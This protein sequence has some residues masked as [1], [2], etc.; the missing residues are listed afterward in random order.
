MAA[1][2]IYNKDVNISSFLFREQAIKNI[3]VSDIVANL[4]CPD[5]EHPESRLTIIING[6]RMMSAPE[7]KRLMNPEGIKPM[8]VDK[9]FQEEIYL[10]NNAEG[11]HVI[12]F[13][14]EDFIH[15]DKDTE[16]YVLVGEKE[17]IQ[18]LPTAEQPAQAEAPTAAAPGFL[19]RV[20]SALREIFVTA[21]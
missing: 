13:L 17:G 6:S 4:P 7:I 20:G 19:A 10:S 14:R 5:M 16:E 21:Q 3:L 8:L 1:A 9:G 18:S 12:T 15:I 11:D 2:A